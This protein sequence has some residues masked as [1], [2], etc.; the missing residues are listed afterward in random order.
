MF[1]FIFVF[2]SL[3]HAGIVTTLDGAELAMDPGDFE[4]GD[5]NFINIE[6]LAKALGGSA[7]WNEDKNTLVLDIPT[8][9]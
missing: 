8:A 6:F 3:F 7:V 1:S 2:P 5:G 9:E 4:F